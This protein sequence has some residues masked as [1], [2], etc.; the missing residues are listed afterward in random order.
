MCADLGEPPFRRIREPV[1]DGP[2][3]RELE[4]AVAQELETL[5]GRGPLVRPRSM[6]EDEVEARGRKRRDQPAELGGPILVDRVATP[7]AR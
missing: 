1:E 6:R 7:G 3:N 5:V 4:D 2:R